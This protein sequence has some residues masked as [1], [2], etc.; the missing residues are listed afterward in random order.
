MHVEIICGLITLLFSAILAMAGMGAAFIFIPIFY[1]L[2]IPL[3]T[4]IPTG[5]FLNGIAL[6]SAS[7]RNIQKR[8][9]PFNLALPIAVISL[10][11]APLGAYSSRYFERPVLLGIFAAF[12]VFS[13]LMILFYR[14]KIRGE[15]FSKAKDITTGTAIG[16]FAGYLSGLVGVGGGGLIS[17]VLIYLGHNPKKV[18]AATAFIVPF[19]S[20]SGFI[21]YAAM[22]HVRLPLLLVT[23]IAAVAGGFLGTWLMNEKMNPAQVRKVIGW[24]ILAVAMK[25][26]Y[27]LFS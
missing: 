18:A 19:S 23:G 16:A 26:I 8:L 4:A 5:L 10:L 21:T 13:G 27:G 20:F 9:V 3:K 12:L 17:P 6:T 15:H 11:M 14:P 25:I 1:W 7:F 2:G 22:G 24:V